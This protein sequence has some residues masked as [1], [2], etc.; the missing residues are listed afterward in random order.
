MLRITG[1]GFC[2][3]LDSVL[4]ILWRVEWCLTKSTRLIQTEVALSGLPH[5]LMP[6]Y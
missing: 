2:P 1:I 6:V 5:Y 4:E 3:I